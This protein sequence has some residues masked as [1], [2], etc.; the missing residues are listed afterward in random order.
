M[1]DL[2]QIDATYQLFASNLEEWLPEGLITIDLSQLHALGLT[3]I[4]ENEDRQLAPI[5][6]QFHIIESGDRITLFNQKFLIWLIPLNDQEE[7]S[8][9][10][11]IALNNDPT[12]KL[13][14]AFETRG[15]YNTS[16][17]VLNVLER[18]LLDIQ[19]NE[20][21]LRKLATAE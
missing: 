17:M 19:E 8:T 13:E 3:Q 4:T 9:I 6:R 1:I 21:L 2:T 12:P 18:Y 16:K 5:T 11:L 20:R 10:A 14:L 7:P 15:V